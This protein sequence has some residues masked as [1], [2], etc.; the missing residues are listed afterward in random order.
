VA[1]DLTVA[2]LPESISVA[3][4]NLLESAYAFKKTDRRGAIWG[5]VDVSDQPYMA[6]IE[7]GATGVQNT[8]IGLEKWTLHYLVLVY[9]R[10]DANPSAVP[11][12]TINA[13]LQAIASALQPI[14]G[15]QTLGATVNNTWIDGEVRIDTGILDQQCALLIP[16]SVDVGV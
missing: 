1:N 12:T 13:I 16:I 6:L 15:K 2:F 5:N 10:A 9:L 14:S 11:A 3:L 7:Q 4:F 8:T